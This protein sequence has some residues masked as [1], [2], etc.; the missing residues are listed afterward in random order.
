MPCDYFPVSVLQNGVKLTIEP[1]KGLKSNMYKSY[2][3]M[4]SDY[5]EGCEKPTQ[6]K[7]L[8]FSLAFFHAIVQERRKFGALGWNIRY[9]FNDSDFE[10]S[11]TL[12]RNFLD[13]PQDVPWDAIIYVVGEISYGGR[14][15]DDWDRRLLLTILGKYI[16]EEALADGYA[17]SESAQYSSPKENNLDGYKS[18]IDA[19]P[20][21]E[22]PEVF[23]MN[24]NANITFKL[25]ESK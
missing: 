17:F 20:N 12:L 21:F 11:Y 4:P 6:W 22:K 13:L 15:T 14:V 7:K 5:F 9:E 24:E 18:I 25:S 16:N 19:L 8:L 3:E 2:S 10:T 1:P 23:G